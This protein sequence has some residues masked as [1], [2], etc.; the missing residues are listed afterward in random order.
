ME[1]ASD[2]DHV[3]EAIIEAVAA[4]QISPSEA[5]ALG[6]LIEARARVMENFEVSS[7]VE[8]LETRMKEVQRLLEDLA[9][10]NDRPRAP[11]AHS[12]R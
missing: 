7:R 4:G 8:G 2:A 10:H 12:Q 5:A 1:R 3:L 11:S 9:R 6:N